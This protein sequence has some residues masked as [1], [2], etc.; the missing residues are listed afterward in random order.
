[1]PDLLKEA[2]RGTEREM[3][4]SAA[5]MGNSSTIDV[6]ARIKTAMERSEIPEASAAMRKK[7]ALSVAI[8]RE[9]NKVLGGTTIKITTPDDI[10]ERFPEKFR[11]TSTGE[12]FL[13]Y[14]EY[15]DPVNKKQM[16]LV[17]MSD[18]GKWVLERAEQLFV[19][20]HFGTKCGKFAQVYIVMGMMPGKSAVPVAFGLLPNKFAITYRRFLE[21]ILEHVT[22]LPGLPSRIMADKEGYGNWV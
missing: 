19:D 1:M 13:R 18:Q 8:R 20:G 4:N 6:I 7:R 2:A 11:V 12:P 16:M 22:F 17:F 15:L 10:K 14:C 5:V 9:R 21:I 3:I